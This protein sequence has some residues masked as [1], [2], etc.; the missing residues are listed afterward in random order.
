MYINYAARL[1]VRKFLLI[2]VSALV[3]LGLAAAAVL[4]MK[5][6]STSTF[7]MILPSNSM[8]GIRATSPERFFET[9]TQ[10][11]LSDT[12]LANAC[13][14]LDDGT[15][16]QKLRSAMTLNG[17]SQ[18]DVVELIVSDK[19]R[20]QSLNRTTAVV[21]SLADLADAELQSIQMTTLWSTVPQSTMLA[22]Q[23][24]AGGLLGG[25]FLGALMILIWGAAARPILDPRCV[26]PELDVDV[27]PQTVVV[28]GAK[29]PV[30]KR[31]M[32]SW[33][34]THEVGS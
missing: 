21:K 8:A 24:L 6:Y 33:L 17:G 25:A 26:S 28:N 32:L 12:V 19:T 29:W 31:E 14:S 34:S 9:E 5:S 4:T 3:G 22:P 30:Q 16:P 20:E 15:T 23:I 1:L 7:I 13:E 18:S 2:V 10:I 11:M 27:Y